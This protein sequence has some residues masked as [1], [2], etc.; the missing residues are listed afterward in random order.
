MRV[1]VTGAG[2]FV[3]RHVVQAFTTAGHDVL[4]LG[5]SA[6]EPATPGVSSAA[7]LSL[8]GTNAAPSLAAALADA[9]VVCHLAARVRVR[10][11]REDPLGYWRANLG[12][13]AAVLGACR[14]S[15]RVVIAST[16]SVYAPSYDPIGED[17]PLAPASP[18]AATKLAADLLA[19]DVA[20]AGGPGVV[21]LRAFNVAGPGDSDTSRVVPALLSRAG[22]PPPGVSSAAMLSPDGTNAASSTPFRVNGDGS[23][24]RDYLHVADIA[25]AFVAAVDAAEPGTWRAYTVG[26]GRGTSVADLV[27]TARR[28]TG[29][30]IPVEHGPAVDEPVRLVADPARIHA[31][32]GWRATRSDPERIVADAWEALTR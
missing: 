29:A 22:Q 12:G 21:S 3:G 7:M 15:T 20:T 4:G 14:P 6:F 18:Y 27:A 25:E 23:A 19:R 1:V 26:S 11:S 32:L 2:G 24:V 8:D 10:E 17:A 5:R 16:C 13:T 9:D 30:D 28:I 31:D